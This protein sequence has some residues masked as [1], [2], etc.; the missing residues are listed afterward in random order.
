[1]EA[2][3]ALKNRAILL[4]FELV[5]HVF[6]TNG[7][8]ELVRRTQIFWGTGNRSSLDWTHLKE[9]STLGPPESKAF[10]V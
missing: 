5:S 9:G 7:A 1:M 10:G 4:V 6:M 3:S 8:S 2:G